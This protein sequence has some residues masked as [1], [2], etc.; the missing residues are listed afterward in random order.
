MGEI[1]QEKVRAWTREGV[2]GAAKV[3]VRMAPGERI[4]LPSRSI[5]RALL[6]HVLHEISDV[7]FYF[8][9]LRR[10]VRPWGRALI[11]DWNTPKDA[12]W[13]GQAGPPPWCRISAS[14]AAVLSA[15]A[16]FQKAGRISGLTHGWG[17]V[18]G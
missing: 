7:E 1:L 18:C 6:I 11:V 8:R 13:V 10:V 5:D 16:G 4:P 17:L 9:E 2:P 15:K 14:R 12:P 3:D